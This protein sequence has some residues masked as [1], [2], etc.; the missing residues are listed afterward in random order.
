[1]PLPRRILDYI[2]DERPD[3]AELAAECRRA[4]THK[5]RGSAEKRL[6]DAYLSDLSKLTPRELHALAECSIHPPAVSAPARGL[7]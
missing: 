4:V 7:C 3:L 2:V 6:A 1:M 5:W